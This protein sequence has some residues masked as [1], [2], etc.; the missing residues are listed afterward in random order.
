MLHNP[1]HSLDN[2]E[3]NLE[4]QEHTVKLGDAAW[5]RQGKEKMP[6]RVFVRRARKMIKE[7]KEALVD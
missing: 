6:W 3:E 4:Y 7:M 5:V 1:V 2:V